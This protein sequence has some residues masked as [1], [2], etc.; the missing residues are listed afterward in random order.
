LGLEVKSLGMHQFRSLPW[1]VLGVLLLASLFFFL[2]FGFGD[3][4]REG[5][6]QG[7]PSEEFTDIS[8]GTSTQGAAPL[9]PGG[10]GDRSH[11]AVIAEDPGR[12]LTLEI[13]DASAR[14]VADL[15]VLLVHS[16]GDLDLVQGW[17]NRAGV[18]L[19]PAP[20]AAARVQPRQRHR[21]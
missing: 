9:A 1:F 7:P 3:E 14:P 10:S 19:F 15:H 2:L 6:S 17:T 12:T 16:D 4:E 11:R 5:G 8:S 18:V 20:Q 21:A 13:H